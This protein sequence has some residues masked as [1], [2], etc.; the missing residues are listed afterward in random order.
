MTCIRVVGIDVREGASGAS[1]DAPRFGLKCYLVSNG[2]RKNIEN[3]EKIK[4][5]AILLNFLKFIKNFHHF[6]FLH[7]RPNDI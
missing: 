5:F 6:F 2:E 3:L 4:K 1:R 7:L